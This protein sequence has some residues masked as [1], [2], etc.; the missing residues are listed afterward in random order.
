MEKIRGHTERD[1]GSKPRRDRS[2]TYHQTRL[3]TLLKEG[4]D[5][6]VGLASKISRRERVGTEAKSL[7]AADLSRVM[8]TTD[9]ETVEFR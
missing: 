2:C 3:P 8:N 4:A 7:Q 9:Q 1:G 6:K 5:I